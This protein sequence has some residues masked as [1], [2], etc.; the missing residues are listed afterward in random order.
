MSQASMTKEGF[1]SRLIQDEPLLYLVSQGDAEEYGFL[2]LKAGPV[3][4]AVDADVLGYL[5]KI[6]KP[7]H[8][9]METGCGYTRVAFATLG[10][11]ISV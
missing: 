3:S 4:W 11:R 6:V 2:G 8:R 1:V 9:T 5:S 10:A 7:H